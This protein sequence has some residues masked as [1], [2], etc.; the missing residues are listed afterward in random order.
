MAFFEAAPRETIAVLKACHV[1]CHIVAARDNCPGHTEERLPRQA[2]A[3]RKLSRQATASPTVIN[4]KSHGT[5]RQSS[6]HITAISS[7]IAT[8]SII[9]G[10][11]HS[12]HHGEVRSKPRGEARGRDQGKARVKAR[13]EA[14]VKAR[15]MARV[16]CQ[17]G[18]PAA[19]VEDC[20]RGWE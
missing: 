16:G 20:A 15:G 12:K 9:H 8:A 7:A 17:V 19:P 1:S 5:P 18:A 2:L 10:N 3:P 11:T 13:R 6:R 14:R 4:D